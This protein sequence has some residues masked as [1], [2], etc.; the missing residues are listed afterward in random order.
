[1]T[2]RG[3]RL[4]LRR[5]LDEGK[6]NQLRRLQDI[7][8]S[9]AMWGGSVIVRDGFGKK[10]GSFSVK[11]M[12][13]HF[14]SEG[15]NEPNK[16]IWKAK[17]PLKIKILMWL[18]HQNSILTKNNL[19]R[20]GWNGDSKCMFCRENESILHLLFECSMAKYVWSIV[21]MVVGG[22][23]KPSSFDQ[24]CYWV[25]I[26]IPRAEKLHLVGLAGICWALWRTR[27][28]VCF[29]GKN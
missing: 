8:T 23:C 14:F 18:I 15:T 6:Q 25:K 5:W 26:F 20:R 29:D 1:M 9:F 19:S 27:N 17:L 24:F 22:D 16:K 28:N 2:Q 3:W 21:E 11:S 4:T 13:K 12:Y 10:N 7:T